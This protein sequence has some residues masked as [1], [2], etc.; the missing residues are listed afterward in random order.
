M[1]T[2]ASPRYS[3][4]G[5][6]LHW[7]TAVVVLIAFAFGPG[8]SE[9]RVYSSAADFDRQL[10]ETLGL[11]VLALVLLRV[12]WRLGARTPAPP[13]AP[14]WMA[15]AARF[16][17]WALYGLLFA[18]PLTAVA[19][20][21]L[22]GHALTL[23][24]G[25]EIGSPVAEAHAAGATLAEVHTWLGDT[26]LWLAGLHASAALFHHL[27]LRDGVLVSMLPRWLLGQR[28]GTR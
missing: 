6:S 18:L 27:V 10:H 19:G 8:G 12:V 7:A 9:H 22:E 3:A 24:A 16:V 23:L 15:R 11:L 25:L 17:Q 5:Q 1:P 13:A 2:N 20:A 21:W 26:I 14:A 4:I 28:P